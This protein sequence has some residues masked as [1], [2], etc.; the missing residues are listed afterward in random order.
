VSKA[1]RD[2]FPRMVWIL[3]ALSIQDCTSALISVTRF[4]DS[5]PLSVPDLSD[6]NE[7]LIS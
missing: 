1:W 7:I 6:E 3:V 5:I 2:S 4:A